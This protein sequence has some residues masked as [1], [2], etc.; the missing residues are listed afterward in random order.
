M[1]KTAKLLFFSFFMVNTACGCITHGSD[2]TKETASPVA[3]GTPAKDSLSIVKVGANFQKIMLEQLS[4]DK[5]FTEAYGLFSEGGWSDDGQTWVLL[6]NDLTQK[7]IFRIA[8][9]RD[10]PEEIQASSDL[11]KILKDKAA[12]ASALKSIEED[13]FDGLIYEYTFLKKTGSEIKLIQNTY[14]KTTD[15]TK[16]PEHE[17]LVNSFKKIAP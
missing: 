16:H 13:M 12:T 17:S 8:A 3:T 5:N 7:K 11:V 4:N 15:L 9:N 14:I 6:N 2:L 1:S 10:K